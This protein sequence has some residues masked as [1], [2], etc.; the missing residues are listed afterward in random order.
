[1]KLTGWFTQDK[2][3]DNN[4]IQTS[5]SENTEQ[6]NRQIRSLVPGQTLR[7]EIVSREGSNAHARS[8]A[9]YFYQ[10]EA[11]HPSA[12]LSLPPYFHLLEAMPYP[13]PSV[14]FLLLPYS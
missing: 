5:D 4:R 12:A 9:A 7:G 10:W 13:K 2:I 3:A 6:A 14:L 11:P 8:A 1:M